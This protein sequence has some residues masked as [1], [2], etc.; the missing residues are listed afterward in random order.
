VRTEFVAERGR[1]HRAAV[2]LVGALL[3]AGVGSIVADTSMRA[4]AAVTATDFATPG[5]DPWGTAFDAAGKVWVA[6]PGCDPA[7]S[8]AAS[9]PPGKLGL[10][11]PTSQSFTTTVSLP[12]GYGQPLFVAVDRNGAVWFTLP[13]TNAIG[14]Y[15]PTT[16]SVTQWP[17]PTAGAGPWGIALDSTGK[18]WFTEHYTNK[19]GSF[20]PSSQTFKE[21]ATVAANSD[22]YGITVDASNNIWFTENT[23]AVAG[24]VEYT[25][26]GVLKEYKIRRTSTSGTG[27]TPHLI[28]LDGHRNVWWT[29]GF[30][31]ALGRLHISS[32]RPGTN[33]SVTE[34]V[35]TPTC[36]SCGAHTSGI[37]I[38]SNGLVWLDDSLQNT[39]AS[40]SPATSLF[41]FSN[42]P[43][44][45]AHPHDGLNVDGQNRVWFDEEFANRLAVAVQSNSTTTTTSTSTT[46]ASSTTTSSS[47]STS[48]TT[49]S[50]STTTTSVPTTAVIA[51][52][53]FQRAN[54]AGWGTATDGHVW[55]ADANTSGSFSIVNDAGQIANTGSTT[56]SGVLGP[57]SANA[58]DY[59]TG[60]LS[61][62]A[63]SNF[64]DVQ[65]WTD[66][67]N[68]YKAYIDGTNL[69]IQKKVASVTTVLATTPFPANAGTSYTIHFRVN[70]TTLTVNAWPTSGT[71]PPNW[72]LTTSDS[73]FS[74]GNAGIRVLTQTGTATIT[75]FEAD[76]P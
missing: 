62:F 72:M 9:T 47:T 18:V 75:R 59:V 8:C 33:R 39:F 35:Y 13:V 55:G 19:I 53:T 57:T 7:P 50:S 37:G 76:T 49:T 69:V 30:V 1:L 44:A 11:D 10:F 27:L 54:Q 26:G 65:R 28:R 20:D 12:A 34:Y 29:E 61:S 66:N 2:A 22:P 3:V 17:V 58:E 4:V 67:N 14:R 51:T 48:S 15:D 31:H 43:T 6:M 21:V 5:G 38:D 40:F 74:S 70:G 42:T 73:T 56:V 36:G 16:T 23:D 25:T 63:N 45:A 41:T 71:E 68:W 24:I 60:S 46:S 32:A 64:G 52:D